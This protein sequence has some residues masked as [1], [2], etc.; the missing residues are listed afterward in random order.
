MSTKIRIIQLQGLEKFHITEF[1]TIRGIDIFQKP[2][3]RQIRTRTMRNHRRTKGGP[4]VRKD[5]YNQGKNKVQT[6]KCAYCESFMYLI[7]Q[8]NAA[9]LTE[10]VSYLSSKQ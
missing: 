10:L 1:C 6:S 5:A 4:P 7:V 9:F 2:Y 8:N 3:Y